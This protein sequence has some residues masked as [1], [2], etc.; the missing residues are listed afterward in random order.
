ME[1]PR[2]TRQQTRPMLDPMAD[3]AIQD[4][5][6]QRRLLLLPLPAGRREGGDDL[7]GRKVANPGKEI[8]IKDDKKVLVK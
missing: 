3:Q 5:S 7:S 6:R 1:R 8:Y 4:T 2:A